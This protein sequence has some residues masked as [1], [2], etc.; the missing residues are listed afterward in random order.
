MQNSIKIIETV[1]VY[2]I[3]LKRFGFFV[4]VDKSIVLSTLSAS[5]SPGSGVT[6]RKEEEICSQF[7]FVA[8]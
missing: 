7:P 4:T 8:R 1:L 3:S 5:S 2:H 6:A